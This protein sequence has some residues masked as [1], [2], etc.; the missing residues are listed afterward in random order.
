MDVIRTYVK[1]AFD[2]VTQSREAV[3]QQQKLV[4]DSSLRLS[5]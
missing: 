4:S 1:S 3:E 2:G 5:P